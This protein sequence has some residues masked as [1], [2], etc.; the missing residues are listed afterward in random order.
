MNFTKNQ[1]R[2]IAQIGET[3]TNGAA[4]DAALEAL[5]R[6]FDKVLAELGEQPDLL[7]RLFACIEF[8]ATR[9]AAK[10]IAQHSLR[11]DEVGALVEQM[12]AQAA[13]EQAARK[14]ER[15]GNRNKE[16]KPAK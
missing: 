11:R 4:Q 9:N 16:D 6:K 7:D 10:L 1:Q 3:M 8:H 12:Q 13:N 14:A 5:A 15:E 2:V